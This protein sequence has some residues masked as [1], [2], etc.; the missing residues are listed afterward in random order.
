MPSV[1]ALRDAG[2]IVQPPTARPAH[3]ADESALGAVCRGLLLGIP[4][5]LVEYGQ[6]LAQ[7]G[8]DVRQV[9]AL[10]GRGE[11]QADAGGRAASASARA[12]R[13]FRVAML[14]AW[15]ASVFP[16][17]QVFDDLATYPLYLHWQSRY[18]ATSAYGFAAAAGF[19]L[20]VVTAT[21]HRHVEGVKA[22]LMAVRTTTAAADHWRRLLDASVNSAMWQVAL[23][24]SRPRAP[25][26][27]V[28]LVGLG[29]IAQY[30]GAY[31]VV[32]T[33]LYA[34]AD[35]LPVGEWTGFG[36]ALILVWMLGGAYTRLGTYSAARRMSL[37]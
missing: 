1:H 14:V 23:A 22:D 9:R 17:Y 4:E 33:A 8:R 21:G 26:D 5:T 3:D 20:A 19:G 30:A 12:R 31:A 37:C 34:A 35:G 28:P 15:Y 7:T 32:N 16:A 2:R 36:L 18:G 11:R 29:H 27:S 6:T 24:A 25:G 13:R 10:A